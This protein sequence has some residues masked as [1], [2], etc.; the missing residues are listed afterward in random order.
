MKAPQFAFPL[1]VEPALPASEN[2]AIT[3]D[4]L[5]VIFDQKVGLYP[6]DLEE[7]TA[8]TRHGTAQRSRRRR[9]VSEPA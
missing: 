8:I 3:L 4:G 2:E 1:E 9:A 5:K 7:K 6:V